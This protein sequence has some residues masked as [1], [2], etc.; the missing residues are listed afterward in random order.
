[1]FLSQNGEE[2]RSA[3]AYAQ[4]ARLLALRVADD[5]KRPPIVVEA[6]NNGFTHLPSPFLHS[7]R[8]HILS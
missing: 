6:T 8:A 3:A 2:L 5:A 7:Q 4:V 1:M